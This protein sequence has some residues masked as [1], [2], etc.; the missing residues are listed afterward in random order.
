MRLTNLNCSMVFAVLVRKKTRCSSVI[1][2]GT[3]TMRQTKAASMLH[4]RLSMMDF[5]PAALEIMNDRA[6]ESDQRG[7]AACATFVKKCTCCYNTHSCISKTS[8][9]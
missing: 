5:D 1:R 2:E 3:R 4:L 7:H 8:M 9:H 6:T